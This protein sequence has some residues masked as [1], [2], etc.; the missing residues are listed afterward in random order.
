MPR[1]TQGEKLDELSL[2]VAGLSER[3]DTVVREVR[4]LAELPA[5]AQ[6]LESQIGHLEHNIADLSGAIMKLNDGVSALATRIAVIESQLAD[7]K[8]QQDEA[9]RKQWT[10][11][12]PIVGALVNGV[13]AAFIAYFVARKG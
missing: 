13:L 2:T 4:S 6:V 3:L 9:S 7:L 5:R 1:R 8:K 12:A 10:V 11:I